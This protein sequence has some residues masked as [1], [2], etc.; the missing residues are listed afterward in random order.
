MTSKKW[1]A[2]SGAATLAVWF[3]SPA[4]AQGDP[5]KCGARAPIEPDERIVGCT[6]MIE[7]GTAAKITL[8]SAYRFRAREYLKTRDFDHAITDYSQ[9]LQL[10]PQDRFAYI[11]RGDAN[12][13][14]QNFDQAISDYNQAIGIDPKDG[15]AYVNRAPWHI[16][17]KMTSSVHSPIMAEHSTLIRATCALT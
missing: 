1:R 6:V 8:A 9:V 15:R 5:M 17:R 14:K 16:F 12:F 2:V 3:A 13:W 11:S 7:A 10:Y 4:Y